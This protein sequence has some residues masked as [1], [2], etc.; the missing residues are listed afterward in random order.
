MLGILIPTCF[1]LAYLCRRRA[2]LGALGHDIE[3]VLPPTHLEVAWDAIKCT[4]TSLNRLQ[5]NCSNII[6]AMHGRFRFPNVSAAVMTSLALPLCQ[7]SVHDAVYR[8]ASLYMLAVVVHHLEQS[9]VWESAGAACVSLLSILRS[10]SVAAVQVALL[11]HQSCADAFRYLGRR[12]RGNV[13][14]AVPAPPRPPRN[15]RF[16]IPFLVTALVAAT[17]SSW[18]VLGELLY[19][20]D[21]VGIVVFWLTMTELHVPHW[22]HVLLWLLVG[23]LL[24]FCQSTRYPSR[25]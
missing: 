23:A 11:V 16:S 25:F 24:L 15:W 20:W 14:M 5:Q 21:L 22:V 1:A 7:T 13:R 9:T 12:F 3:A 19:V 6:R 18:P 10:C 8:A 2:S 4:W 17:Y